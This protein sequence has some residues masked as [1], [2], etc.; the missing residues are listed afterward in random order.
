MSLRICRTAFSASMR[1][2]EFTG[3]NH[4]GSGGRSGTRSSFNEAAGIHRRKHWLALEGESHVA[5]GFN[6]AAGIHR[7]KREQ[8]PDAR[9]GVGML[10]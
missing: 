4:G 5:R 8:V 3:G 10:Q 7:R 6:E 9:A 2:P 1:P